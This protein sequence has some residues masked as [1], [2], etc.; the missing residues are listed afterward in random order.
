MKYLNY[1]F[2][3]N[4]NCS[5]HTV[6]DTYAYISSEWGKE[7]YHVICIL[8]YFYLNK[9]WLLIFDLMYLLSHSMV[10]EFST[11]T[12]PII[13]K[14]KYLNTRSTNSKVCGGKIWVYKI[15]FCSTHEFTK[16]KRKRAHHFKDCV[17]VDLDS[18]GKSL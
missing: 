9:K 3:T 1:N 8:I 6:K 16:C 4:L 12:A 17:W 10:F 13:I 11:Q 2:N 14:W 18:L 5:G 7:N 15:L